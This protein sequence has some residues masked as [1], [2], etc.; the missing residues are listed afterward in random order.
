M[1]ES[2]L[3]KYPRLKTLLEKKNGQKNKEMSAG[4]P[5]PSHVTAETLWADA[6]EADCADWL[7]F[8]IEE[9]RTSQQTGELKEWLKKHKPSK[10]DMSDGVVWICVNFV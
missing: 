7:I 1:S 2:L 4:T 5:P 6:V 9:P 3:E 8:S 10:V